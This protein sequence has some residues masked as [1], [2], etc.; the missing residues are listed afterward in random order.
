MKVYCYKGCGTCKK[1]LKFLDENGVD[2]EVIPIR[3]QP[4]TKAEL[5]K[6]LKHVDGNLRALFNTSG[7]DYKE[8][9]M[10]EKLPGMSEAEAI[11]LLADRGNL[12]KRPFVL[13]GDFGLVGF[14]ESVWREGLGLD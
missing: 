9:N 2:Y 4:P 6:M 7:G 1:A 3:E 14:K 11:D 5:K 8:L 13:T 10:K 12:V